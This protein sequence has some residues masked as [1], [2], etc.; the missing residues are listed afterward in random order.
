MPRGGRYA[1][2]P[3]VLATWDIR[4]GKLESCTETISHLPHRLHQ[5][6]Y[7]CWLLSTS[8]PK[9]GRE[10]SCCHTTTTYN[11]RQ[12]YASFLN[13]RQFYEGNGSKTSLFPFSSPCLKEDFCGRIMGLEAAQL[14]VKSHRHDSSE[15]T[16]G[17]RRFCFH[18]YTAT[19]QQRLQQ[20]R[21]PIISGARNSNIAICAMSYFRQDPS[22]TSDCSNT[23]LLRRFVS[24]L[25]VHRYRKI[26]RAS[27]SAPAR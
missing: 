4:S 5:E 6:I 2:P 22:P 27:Q 16:R 9:T 13:S 24:Q 18:L 14:R 7:L 15:A 21:N 20:H 17:L 8:V 19:V 3:P 1:I 12:A 23:L 26:S 25:S 10:N 11:S